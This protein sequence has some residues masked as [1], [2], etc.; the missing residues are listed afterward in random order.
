MRVLS[1]LILKDLIIE[2]RTRELLTSMS[3]LAFLALVILSLAFEPSPAMAVS[4]APGI[5]WVTLAFTA[6]LGLAR[7]HA[8]EQERQAFQGLLLTPVSRSLLFLGKFGANLVFVVVLQLVVV[9]AFVVLF[10]P[11]LGGRALWLVPPL[12]LG[13]VGFTAIGTLLGTMTAAT[14]LREVLLPIL[15]LP[16]VLPVII[17]S[18]AGLNAAIDGGA[19]SQIQRSLKLLA[20]V[21]IIYLVLG[22][23]LYEYVAEDAS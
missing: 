3:L 15:L 18:L 7:S 2:V 8:L 20:A 22:M 11:Q 21:D 17:L 4:A 5:L 14:R 9:V 6:T 23:W 1:A 10:S 19:M 13:A 16:V 12:A